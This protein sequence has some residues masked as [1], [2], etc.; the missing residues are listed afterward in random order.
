MTWHRSG[1]PS[2]RVPVPKPPKPPAPPKAPKPAP[3][4]KP[5]PINTKPTKTATYASKKPYMG[6]KH[7]PVKTGH[8]H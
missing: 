2:V 5:T 3:A 8:I 1:V 4:A 7:A 6:G